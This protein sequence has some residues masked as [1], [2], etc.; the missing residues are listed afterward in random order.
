MVE[1]V[2]TGEELASEQATKP[3]ES[4][5]DFMARM[6]AKRA[7]EAAQPEQSKRV[8]ELD[9]TIAQFN[10][11]V[12]NMGKKLMEVIA[13]TTNHRPEEIGHALGMMRSQLEGNI[14]RSEA[15][16]NSANQSVSAAASQ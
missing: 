16:A 3:A 9:K 13:R 6:E 5:D 12:N 15:V 4:L 7:R 2:K 11:S 10:D 14:D 1:R 8:Y